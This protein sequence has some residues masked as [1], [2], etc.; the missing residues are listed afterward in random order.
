MTLNEIGLKH[1]T[2][3]AYAHH[4]LE[5]Y[6]KN[7]PK[8]VKRILEIGVHNGASLKMW[9]EYYPDAEVIGIDTNKPIN[10]EGCIVL[11]LDAK[12]VFALQNLGDFDIVIDDGSHNTLDQQIAY[13]ALCKQ[14]KV[15]IMEDLHTSFYKHYINSSATTVDILKALEKEGKID[16]KFWSNTEDFSDSYTAIIKQKKVGKQNNGST[17]I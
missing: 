11:Q 10:V 2:D 12:D 9:K 13:Y 16:I 7:L 14:A 1:H 3:K 5:F 6:E 8:K 17:S 15:Y 4:Y